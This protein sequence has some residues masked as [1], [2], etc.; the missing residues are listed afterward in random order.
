MWII[1]SRGRPHNITRLATAWL[2]TGA[3]TPALI[4]VDDDD[5]TREVYLGL[6]KPPQWSVRIGA[7][8]RLSDLYNGAF[9]A[10]PDCHW[11]GFL[12]DDV[13][14]E[15]PRWDSILIEAAGR[16]GMAIP[17]GGDTTGGAP[18]FVL[19]GDLV[20]SVG[21]LALPGLDRLY[22][23]TVWYQI[24]KARG[25]AHYRPAVMLRH[26][27]FSNGLALM[28]AT[29]RKKRKAADRAIYETWHRETFKHDNRGE[30]S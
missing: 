28:N 6:E 24:A 14:P 17:A 19:G 29:Y 12:A 9:A 20:R 13:V 2:A 27:H 25:V 18:H 16:D 4:L 7:R 8:K 10:H 22:I 30:P 15:T 11:F 1:P 26:H 23:D 3:S 21:W 5:A